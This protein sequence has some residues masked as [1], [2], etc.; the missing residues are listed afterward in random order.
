MAKKKRRIIEEPEEE[1]EFT[2]TEFNEREFILKEMY[3]TKIFGVAVVMAII[4][5]IVGGILINVNPIVNDGWYLMSIVATAISFGVMFTIK[6]VTSMMGLHPE[7]IEFKSL[8][9]IY[10]IY[11]AL[12][13]GVCIAVVQFGS[14]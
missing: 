3:S 9:G 13:L 6:K 10:L 12:A 4:V 5:G 14:F 8:A 1:Y 7:L 11:L 2:P